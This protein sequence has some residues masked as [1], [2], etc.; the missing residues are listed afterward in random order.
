MKGGEIL[1][2]DRAHAIMDS[3]GVIEVKY[4]DRPVW[5]E[6]ISGEQVM[7][8]FLPDGPRQVVLVRDLTE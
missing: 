3:T 8:R 1:D 2:R 4:H 7:V 6:Q 5:L